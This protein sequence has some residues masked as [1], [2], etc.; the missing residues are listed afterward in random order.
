MSNLNLIKIH[1]FISDS[2]VEYENA[3]FELI[4]DTRHEAFDVNGEPVQIYYKR[5]KFPEI[6]V[7]VGNVTKTLKEINTLWKENN[8]ES[9]WMIDR[10]EGSILAI[11]A[12][13]WS[14][15]NAIY[16]IHLCDRF[17]KEIFH[18]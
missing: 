12:E 9:V 18:L 6:L 11:Q 15:E 7:T 13:N 1:Y 16:F 3:G 2:K 5:Q 10:A 14:K 17:I 8:T 4:A